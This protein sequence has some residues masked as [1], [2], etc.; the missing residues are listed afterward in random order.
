MEESLISGNGGSAA[1]AQHMAAEL[2]CRFKKER[3]AIAALSLCTDS[4]V[5]TSISND[6]DYENIL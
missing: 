1:Q 4:S 5:I 2:V 3:K 6:Y